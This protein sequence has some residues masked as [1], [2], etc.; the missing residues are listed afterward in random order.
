MLQI[1]RMRAIPDRWIGVSHV[2]P[3]VS[4]HDNLQILIDWVSNI[5]RPHRLDSAVVS[6]C[7]NSASKATARYYFAQTINIRPK[8]KG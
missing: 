8:R 7:P 6:I 1:D 4:S 5:A 3:L 2:L